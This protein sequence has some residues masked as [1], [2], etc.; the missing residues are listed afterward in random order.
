MV[1][2]VVVVPVVVPVFV[3]DSFVQFFRNQD[4]TW[5]GSQNSVMECLPSPA[6]VSVLLLPY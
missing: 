5:S 2:A 6:E 1:A 3:V 4:Y